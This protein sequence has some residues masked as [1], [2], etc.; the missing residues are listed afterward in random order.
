MTLSPK[1]T[2]EELTV[3]GSTRDLAIKY[4]D[5]EQA[6]LAISSAKYLDK[7]PTLCTMEDWL[8]REFDE[9]RDNDAL[10]PWSEECLDGRRRG[11]VC[12]PR[13]LGSRTSAYPIGGTSG[14]E[15]VTG[16]LHPGHTAVSRLS[17]LSQSAVEPPLRGAY[18]SIRV[19]CQCS[20]RRMKQP[21]RI[22]RSLPSCA[23]F[24]AFA[25]VAHSQ[26]FILG[27]TGW[28]WAPLTS[29]FTFTADQSLTLDGE[30]MK[31]VLGT[32][33][34]RLAPMGYNLFDCTR[35]FTSAS[36]SGGSRGTLIHTP[37]LL[38]T[39]L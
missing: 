7:S 38:H 36:P 32:A 2:P 21:S 9:A 25:R 11:C 6:W 30:M 10:L 18:R 20:C 1:Q 14:G 29:R 23:G 35:F 3:A 4:L 26:R 13:L 8:Q 5:A 33:R 37:L 16:V 39:V 17:S 27:T 12:Y 31:E 19:Y 34:D 24:A 15:R 22:R 28:G